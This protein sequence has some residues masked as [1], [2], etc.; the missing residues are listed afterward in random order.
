MVWVE[1]VGVAQVWVRCTC[2]AC[3]CNP[4]ARPSCCDPY[5]PHVI[6]PQ[7]LQ[8][9]RHNAA[10][11]KRRCAR[12]RR[13][14]G[15]RHARAAGCLLLAHRAER[16]LLA[17]SHSGTLPPFFCTKQ[18]HLVRSDPNFPSVESGILIPGVHPGSPAERAGLRAGDCIIGG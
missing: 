13:R 18:T 17:P 16:A 3:A 12:R 5:T 6:H 10:Q 2:R 4:A 7:M 15:G 8:L 11:F 1:Q 9:T 14:W